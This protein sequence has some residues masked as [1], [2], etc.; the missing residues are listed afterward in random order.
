MSSPL[1]VSCHYRVIVSLSLTEPGKEVVGLFKS[2][3]KPI[4]L[5]FRDPALFF[6]LLNSANVVKSTSSNDYPLITTTIFPGYENK[7][8]EV[9][10]VQRV[11]VRLIL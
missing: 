5:T 8:H 1:T 2:S 9:L 4:P 3:A 7:D 6:Q 11:S 10:A